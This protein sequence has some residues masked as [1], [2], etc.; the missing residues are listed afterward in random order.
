MAGQSVRRGELKSCGR[1]GSAAEPSRSPRRSSPTSWRT[2]ANCRTSGARASTG[3]TRTITPLVSVRRS[4]HTESLGDFQIAGGEIVM[5]YTNRS[6][7]R[8]VVR[9]GGEARGCQCAQEPWRRAAKGSPP[10]R[11]GLGTIWRSGRRLSPSWHFCRT[12]A[13]SG[14]PVLRWFTIPDSPGRRITPIITPH[15]RNRCPA[16]PYSDPGF[17]TPYGPNVYVN[18]G[19]EYRPW[20]NWTLRRGRLQ[21][22]GARGQ[23]VVQAQLLLPT[24]RIQRGA[25]LADRVRPLPLLNHE[26]MTLNVTKCCVEG[27][28]MTSD[29]RVRSSEHVARR[30]ASGSHNWP[31]TS[32][33]W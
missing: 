5:T 31:G 7:A 8:H 25:G 30:G 10:S 18:L 19:L 23:D 22:R 13:R 33:S 6:H 15:S 28:P 1:N 3:F 29:G 17:T 16:L 4:Y 12:S 26:P 9:R 24:F 14:R 20:T 27:Q 32:S 11:T 2:T 21:P